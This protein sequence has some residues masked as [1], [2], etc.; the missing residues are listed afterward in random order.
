M[1]SFLTT[2]RARA[3]RPNISLS[4]PRLTI[5]PKVAARA[6]RVPFVLLVVTVLTGGLIGLLLLNTAL[7]R[8]AY[9]VTDL[10]ERSADLALRQQH[11]GLQVAELQ[12]PQRLAE[13]AVA[14]GMV[15]NDNPAFLSLPSGAIVGTPMPAVAEN[16]VSIA[17]GVQVAG[18]DSGKVAP[19]VAGAGNSQSTGTEH[20]P[21]QRTGTDGADRRDG[22]DRGTPK[23]SQSAQR[24][25]DRNSS[26]RGD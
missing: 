26:S 3:L 18:D 13:Q 25:R 22:A 14:L 16:Q 7:Q 19:P 1:S 9:A 17:Y 20:E 11:L 2:A 6:P 15:R 4:R 8:G 5:V 23:R 10:R 21:A 24:P 12:Q